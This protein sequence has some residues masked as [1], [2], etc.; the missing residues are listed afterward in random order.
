MEVTSLE[1]RF[2]RERMFKPIEEKMS[3]LIHGGFI[4]CAAVLVCVYFGVKQEMKPA[5]GCGVVGLGA[6]VFS[7]WLYLNYRKFVK[8]AKE[9]GSSMEELLA[10]LKKAHEEKMR[11]R[12]TRSNTDSKV[13]SEGS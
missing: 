10:D 6:A 9:Q 12:K 8:W 7:L 3:A 1:C 11:S 2:C 5:L 13:D 4:T